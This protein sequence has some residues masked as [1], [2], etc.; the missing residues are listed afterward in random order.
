MNIILDC[1]DVLLDWIGRF[2]LFCQE[3]LGRSFDPTNN[4]TWKMTE[5]LGVANEEALALIVE[6]NASHH[7]AFLEPVDGAREAIKQLARTRD[8]YVLTACSTDPEVVE[9]RKQN[10]RVAFDDVFSAIWCLEA[11][12]QCVAAVHH[13][14]A[15]DLGN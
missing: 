5:W 9:R 12:S 1:D 15:R 7:F 8:L 4:T 14:N 3:R 11:E 10:L 2:R 13:V 6:F